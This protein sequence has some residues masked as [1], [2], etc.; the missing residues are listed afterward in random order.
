MGRHIGNGHTLHRP[1]P[2]QPSP[3]TVQPL[4]AGPYQEFFLHNIVAL[5]IMGVATIAVG[6]GIG[7]AGSWLLDGAEA[8]TAEG[9]S[10]W[11]LG[12]GSRGLAIEQQ[13][14]GNLPAGFPV[15]DAFQNGVATSMK[16]I[17]L[18]A[19]S[20]Q[21]AQ[22][23]SSQLN[24]YVD[25]LAGWEGQTTPYGGVVIQPGQIAET[26]LQIGF[27]SGA[28][29]TMQQGVFDAVAARAQSLGVNLITTPIP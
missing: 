28:M 2:S 1:A 19:G 25:A 9:G 14:G 6:E 3:F 23:L 7:L 12:W 15:V 11:D 21:S 26:T 8:T 22:T 27:P 17:D 4:N 16:S 18:S 29:S 5:A 13:L 10:V 24:G 20:Y